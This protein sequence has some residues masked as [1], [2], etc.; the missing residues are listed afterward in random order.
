MDSPVILGT[1]C[2]RDDE[3]KI[4]KMKRAKR[5]I[6]LL[7]VLCAVSLALSSCGVMEFVKS[8]FGTEQITEKATEEQTTNKG[9]FNNGGFGNRKD[10]DDDEEEEDDDDE[11][12]EAVLIYQIL[13]DGTYGVQSVTS[14]KAKNIEIPAKYDGIKVTAILGSAFADMEKLES[15]TIPDSV[16]EIGRMAFANCTGLSN[17]KIGED[18]K[19]KTIEAYA[20]YNCASLEEIYLPGSLESVGW[21]AFDNC[22]SLELINFDGDVT[23]AHTMF[24]TSS[25]SSQYAVE[26]Q[27][28]DGY[29][30]VY[31]IVQNL[32]VSSESPSEGKTEGRSE[33]KSESKTEGHTEV[34]TE[35]ASGGGYESAPIEDEGNLEYSVYTSYVAVTGYSGNESRV[36]IPD[37][38]QGRPVK[39]IEGSVFSHNTSLTEIVISDNVTVIGDYAFYYC[40][41][42]VS[43]KLPSS[44]ESIGND[45]FGYCASLAYIDIPE[46]VTS[47][48]SYAFYNCSSLSNVE[49]PDSITDIGTFAFAH[50]YNFTK[51]SIGEGVYNI[52]SS[53]FYNCINV[54]TIEIPANVAYIDSWAFESC[55]SLQDVYYQGTMEEAQAFLSYGSHFFYQDCYVN[56]TNGIYRLSD[57]EVISGET[58][59]EGEVIEFRYNVVEMASGASYAELL[60]YSGNASVVEIPAY[61]EGY[62][63]TVIANNAF[64]SATVSTVIIPDT[65]TT[66]GAEAFYNCSYLTTINIPDS[67]KNIGKNAFQYCDMVRELYNSVYYVDGWAVEYNGY[68]SDVTLKE[69]TR[70]I[71]SRTFENYAQYLETITIPD[72][73]TT[74][75]SYA[76]YGCDALNAVYMGNGVNYIGEYAFYDCDGIYSIDIPEGVTAIG[77]YTFY[78]CDYLH[79]VELPGTLQT[80]GDYAFAYCNNIETMTIPEGVTY[81]GYCG[82]YLC[83]NLKTLYVPASVRALGNWVFQ[84][85]SL[86][87]IHYSGTMAQAKSVLDYANHFWSDDPKIICTDGAYKLSTGNVLEYYYS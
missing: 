85:G 11:N 71:A 8:A 53:A 65:V 38:Y 69:G 43:V 48:G 57:N 74:I 6:V 82:F 22:L 41:N 54:Q 68:E 26:I 45:V 86:D 13:S 34:K 21:Y 55:T 73:V 3:R 44:L 62:P 67:V 42:L 61:F 60:E 23:T 19:L 15:V 77:E 78:E 56:C 28:F 2:I 14:K 50:C 12:D 18:S 87:E 37:Y 30:Y 52:G 4:M 40:E 39:K 84:C 46:G 51:I 1:V 81:V 72:S 75:S 36:V 49:M 31:N 59:T 32:P 58:S 17:V 7:A 83:S 35:G 25:I 47:I 9:G 63:I 10:D 66:I 76:F 16:K 5:I 33:G 80:I 70:G 20:F 79:L 64:S 24:G 27:C 29:Y